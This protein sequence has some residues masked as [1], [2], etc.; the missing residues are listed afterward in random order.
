MR[1]NTVEFRYDTFHYNTMMYTVRLPQRKNTGQI[2]NS[3][4]THHH[5]ASRANYA[6]AIVSTY[7][8]KNAVL[9][10]D[11]AVSPREGNA[12]VSAVPVGSY[13]L[14]LAACMTVAYIHLQT[15]LRVA[16]IEAGCSACR[17]AASRQ[18]DKLITCAG[19]TTGS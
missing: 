8:K 9:L 18:Y 16:H 12:A 7:G 1:R 11:R 3:Q 14:L 10:R 13:H 4:K 2:L 17:Q 19:N 5:L 15:A 6:A